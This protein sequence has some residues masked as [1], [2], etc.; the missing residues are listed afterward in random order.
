MCLCDKE[1]VS[2]LSADIGKHFEEYDTVKNNIN[3]I[4]KSKEPLISEADQTNVTDIV[5][6]M[7]DQMDVNPPDP[8]DTVDTNHCSVQQKKIVDQLLTDY[9]DAFASHRYD[10][11]SFTGFVASIEVQPGSTHIEKERPMKID[12]KACLQPI[13][14][15]LVKYDIL[16]FADKQ[17]R[18]LAN[19]HGV[20]KPVSGMRICGKADQFIMKQTGQKMDYSRLTVDL[21]G[22][23][24]KCPSG[25]KMNLPTY[26]D[27]VKKFKKKKIS[28][29]DIRSMYWSIHINYESQSLTN[30]FFNRH[31]MAFQRLPMGYK[32]SCYIGQ[33]ASELTYSQDSLLKFLQKK[34]WSLNSE[35]FPFSD[36][37]EFLIVFCDDI[38]IFTPDDLPDSDKIHQHV[39][40]FVLWATMQYGFKI[41]RSK[42]EPYVS[43]FKFLGHFFDVQKA[44]TMIPP[45]KLEHFKQFRAPASTAEALSRISSYHRTYIP[46]FKI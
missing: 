36:V 11:G 14:D 35:E 3:E 2:I 23:D 6:G 10:V 12:A 26:Y 19:S 8:G 21:R 40:E 45:S 25:P 46:L 39:V 37:S 30:F 4:R 7:L 31:V 20:A 38:V 1:F 9:A 29:F 13:V 27:L 41:G 5:E 34:G 32:N 28:T 33:R 43:R 42:Y 16:K 24:S 18:F 17:D 15:N 44:C 22:L